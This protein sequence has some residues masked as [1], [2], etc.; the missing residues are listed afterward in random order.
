M[1]GSADSTSPINS[2]RKESK[3][4]AFVFDR[5]RRSSS[6][7]RSE[8]L[9][10]TTSP[11]SSEPS[12]PVLSTKQGNNNRPALPNDSSQDAKSSSS[13]TDKTT[14]N[15]NNNTSDQQQKETKRKDSSEMD[16][17]ISKRGKPLF[18][19]SGNL[20]AHAASQQQ[21]GEAAGW[22]DIPLSPGRS[23]VVLDVEAGK[24]EG[25]PFSDL[26]LKILGG[27]DPAKNC[28]RAHTNARTKKTKR[29]SSASSSTS[30]ASS[31][32]SS[33]DT[34][35]NIPLTIEIVDAN[36]TINDLTNMRAAAASK[37]K[38]RL[39]WNMRRKSLGPSAYV[40]V[41]KVS[42]RFEVEVKDENASNNET[43]P[44]ATAATTTI[45]RRDSEDG[46]G[47]LHH[48]DGA[49]SDA[50]PSESDMANHHVHPE[51]KRVSHSDAPP[52]EIP[53]ASP[54][55]KKRSKTLNKIT[56]QKRQAFARTASTRGKKSGVVI[57]ES[58]EASSSNTDD[59]DEKGGESGDKIGEPH[60][61]RKSNS[62]SSGGSRPNVRK[63][64]SLVDVKTFFKI[65]QDDKDSPGN[66]EGNKGRK[67]AATPVKK[68]RTKT[69]LESSDGSDSSA[70]ESKKKSKSTLRSLAS[71]SKSDT[72]EGGKMT[73]KKSKA[74]KQKELEEMSQ[75][76]DDSEIE[77][78]KRVTKKARPS[79]PGS[80][81]SITRKP[82]PTF[83]APNFDVPRVIEW[84]RSP[85]PKM[86]EYDTKTIP[87][88]LF[89]MAERYPSHPLFLIK[90]KTKNNNQEASTG[91]SSSSSSSSASFSAS[92][93]SPSAEQTGSSPPTTIADASPL[94][95]SSNSLQNSSSSSFSSSSAP[96]KKT[97]RK[98]VTSSASP[99]SSPRT[100]DTDAS[101]SPSSS[102]SP[103]AS[104]ERRRANSFAT[105][106]PGV[107]AEWSALSFQ[108]CS[109]QVKSVAR[110]LMGL[111]LESG[112]RTAIFCHN[113]PEWAI[114]HL[115]CM[116]AGCVPVGIP[117]ATPSQEA[118]D[119]LRRCKANVLLVGNKEQWE[120][121][122]APVLK[123]SKQQLRFV[124]CLSSSGCDTA[125]REDMVLLSWRQF[126]SRGKQ[127]SSQ[128]LDQRIN[129]LRPE[130]LATV[131]Y[132]AG[133]FGSSKGVMLSHQNLIW[134]AEAVSKTLELRPTDC[135][136]SFLSLAHIAD[137]MLSIYVPIIS[138][139]RIFFAESIHT[140]SLNLR[141]V[142][143]TLLLAP[144]E[145]W[146]KLYL[147]LKERLEIYDAGKK[148]K[149]KLNLPYISALWHHLGCAR[150]RYAA[151][152]YGHMPEVNLFARSVF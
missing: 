93:S 110:A 135:M 30:S 74:K 1:S 112:S 148:K 98:N 15:S 56:E 124:V 41:T 35:S 68:K 87:Q 51:K 65:K 70:A 63:T 34:H 43:S 102:S 121:Q 37:A 8:G 96:V 139:C 69:T 130:K 120:K 80:T 25:I 116:A 129:S 142:Q 75:P 49:M 114:F 3:L 42:I 39:S 52:T 151:V 36:N 145:L 10:V 6:L 147:S 59:S 88:R 83:T 2:P 126:M 100:G 127:V 125:A 79:V 122:L 90:D 17:S 152:G 67:T 64:F 27:D 7:S 58:L 61:G 38:R 40:D 141:E 82:P 123:E 47:S 28:I 16:R 54:G 14:T 81:P 19:S 44:R 23:K 11:S 101:E 131:C 48:S 119:L 133:T 128:A 57:K 143:P 132:T 94:T 22:L 108:E 138:R 89:E 104:E 66:N 111:G 5:K 18:S 103:S 31:S 92:T 20:I 29:G 117:D 136:L 107:P 115:G 76:E 99:M 150:V 53:P 60:S 24:L 4:K 73:S 144:P 33:S 137:Q 84:E 72:G 134:T 62:S 146:R 12:S 77:E 71:S 140:L 50:S 113:C 97:Y 85:P 106:D 105:L 55:T 13:P 78:G 109:Q 9:H 46:S 21:Q 26:L 149:I 118:A 45:K 91:A 32:P 95:S 86:E